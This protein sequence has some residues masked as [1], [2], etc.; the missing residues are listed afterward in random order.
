M[1]AKNPAS[2]MIHDRSLIMNNLSCLSPINRSLF[3]TWL[4]VNFIV[5]FG[6]LQLIFLLSMGGKIEGQDTKRAEVYPPE[7]AEAS[8]EGKEAMQAIKFPEGWSV[9]LFAAEPQ[10]ANVVSIDIDHQGRIYVGETFRQN[11]GVTDNRGHDDKWLLA[12]LAAE[13]VQDRIDYHRELLGDAA[14]TYEQHDDRIRRLEDSNG[15][16]VAD[17]SV[18]VANGFNR[19]EEGTGAG[20]LWRPSG[21]YYACIPKLWKLIDQDD[22]GVIDQRIVMADG[23]GVRVAF[24]G[25]DLHGLIVGPDGRLY[26]SIGDRGYHVRTDDGRLLANPDSGA[27]FRC[28]LDGTGLEVFCRGLR[29]PQEL[30]FNDVGDFFTVDNNSDSGDQ[31]RVV[32]L[33]QESDSGWRM[34]Y[35][36]LPDRGPFNRESLWKPFHPEQPAYIV[37]PLKNFTDGPSGFAYY[38]GTGFGNKFRDTFFICDFRGGAANSGVRTFRL[39]PNGATYQFEGDEKPIW[40]LLA[41]DI[42]FGPDGSLFV[43]DW[44]NGWDGLGKGRIYKFYDPEFSESD[45]VRDVQQRLAA[46]WSKANDDFLVEGLEHSDRRLRLEAQWELAGRGCWELL[47]DIANNT[48][49]NRVTRLHGIWG[50]DQVARAQP[51]LKQSISVKIRELLSDTDDI[52]RA[53]AVKFVG[54]RDDRVAIDSARDL[55]QDPS[56][57]VRYFALRAVGDFQDSSVSDEIVRI[58]EKEASE[59]PAIRHAAILALSKTQSPERLK[60]LTKHPDS[61]VR[62]SAVVALRRLESPEAVAFLQDSDASVALEAAR[63]IYDVPIPTAMRTLSEQVSHL[64]LPREFFRRVLNANYRM[65][66]AKAAERL[67]EFA[68]QTTADQEMRLEAL[69]LLEV[70]NPSDPRDRVLNDY[71]PLE[72][73]SHE[74]AAEALVP[75]LPKLMTSQQEVRDEAIRVA[76]QLGIQG[77]VPMLLTRIE[78]KS[79][80]P[81]E[82]AD[83]L[84]ALARLDSIA[85]VKFASKIRLSPADDLLISALQVLA[86]YDSNQ[87]IDILIGA[88]ASRELRVKQVAWDL[89]APIDHPKVQAEIDRNL[90]A[91]VRGDLSNDIALNLIETAQGRLSPQQQESVKLY[92]QGINENDPLGPWLLAIEGGDDEAG[93]KLF[94][95]DA[96]LSCLRCHQI[97]RSGG[98]VGPNLTTIGAKKNRRYLLESI[99]LPDASVAT[100][101]ETAV[102]LTV[103]GNTVAGI[104]KS[105]DEEQ[106]KL[107]KPDGSL[108]QLKLTD[109]EARKKGKSSMPEDLINKLSLRQLRDLVAYLSSLQEESRVGHDTE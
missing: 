59:D 106:I 87:S 102:I 97:G 15:D 74:I 85:A 45:V 34:Y 20:V 83:A 4:S 31:A 92:Q 57:R 27:V 51:S 58:I 33:L 42:A 38:P 95:E 48:S 13:T 26:F 68:G 100:G 78:D 104:V 46:D 98:Q 94:F 54:E 84:D 2:A 60:S 86:K 43:S 52:I 65:G 35:Q 75:Y 72:P 91:Y 5:A 44:V 88:T 81:T 21:L 90:E 82:R 47:T 18:V 40:T 70:W 14:V 1:Q 39:K 66:T 17:I 53:A 16:G 7:V 99:C 41:T 107:I 89:L 76:S 24:R 109:I 55:L 37:P 69:R 22:N 62:R 108:V 71:R 56:A 96:R 6:S 49:Q 77:I 29:N 79:L 3:G 30:A 50:A 64:S 80:S 63:A 67:A 61:E 101:F 28:E 32:H 25:H 12:D 8:N 19:L 103:E 11:R 105:E 9:E 93:R 23:F 10:V 36:Y 73:R